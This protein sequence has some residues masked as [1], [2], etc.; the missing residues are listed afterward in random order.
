MAIKHT[1]P[2]RPH[3]AAKR[4]TS[5]ILQTEKQRP[6][7]AKA[8]IQGQSQQMAELGL[9]PCG[10]VGRERQ[11]PSHPLSPGRCPQLLT[12]AAHFPRALLAL[13]GHFCPLVVKPGVP[14]KQTRK[15]LLHRAAW[16]VLDTREEAWQ[17][18]GHGKPW[19]V[20]GSVPTVSAIR[21]RPIPSLGWARRVTPL[22]YEAQKKSTHSHRGTPRLGDGF[23]GD[24]TAEGGS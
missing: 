10:L 22:P 7:E 6:R 5:P 14:S 24:C 19:G 9:Q 2:S 4:E 11:T 13:E 15:S 20:P 1:A 17:R 23:Q 16:S 3:K 18:A 12:S 21:A 8:Y